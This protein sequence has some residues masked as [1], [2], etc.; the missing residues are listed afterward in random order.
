[1][2]AVADAQAAASSSRAA[3]SAARRV[4]SFR[5]IAMS[6]RVPRAATGR[7][8]ALVRASSSRRP[9]DDGRAAYPEA[10]GRENAT[11]APS[12]RDAL[13]RFAASLV[14]ALSAESGFGLVAPPASRAMFN[15]DL[16]VPI[17]DPIQAIAVI[18]AVR[19]CIKDILDQMELFS[20]TCPAPTFPCDLSQLNTK[21]STRVSGPLARALPTLTEAYGADPYAVQDILQSVTQTESMLKSNNARVKVDFEGPRTFLEL[22]DSSIVAFLEEVP[23]EKVAEGKALFDACDLDV[24]ATAPGSLECRLGRAV[25]QNARPSGG[26]G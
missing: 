2:M 5:P 1:M 3:A 12:R 13:G 7:R 19:A 8:R 17:E 15:K 23:A 4:S 11:T 10:L 18:Y 21:A 25:A 14:G 16:D 6:A 22:V 26:I 24:D 9:S 20:T